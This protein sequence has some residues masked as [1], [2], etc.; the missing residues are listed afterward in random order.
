MPGSSSTRR[1]TDS[2][3]CLQGYT[4]ADTQAYLLDSLRWIAD[5]FV[6]CHHA[7]LAFTAQVGDVN[8]D[9]SLWERSED[10]LENRPSFDVTPSLPGVLYL[11]A[12]ISAPAA[13]GFRVFGSSGS[14]DHQ[15]M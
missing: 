10:M 8:L 5:Y 3:L 6:E 2:L 1:S 13:V 9:H 12:E 15:M 11:S 7:D 14:N 4:N